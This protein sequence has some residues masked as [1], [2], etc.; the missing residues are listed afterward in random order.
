MAPFHPKRTTKVTVDA[1]MGIG[2]SATL[3]QKQSD[4]RW[5]AVTHHSRTFSAPEKNY[6]QIEAESVAILYGITRNK[7]YLQGLKYFEVETDHKP[8]LRLYQS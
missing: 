1:A 5:K 4:G 8:L 7:L 2:T 3:W 6:S